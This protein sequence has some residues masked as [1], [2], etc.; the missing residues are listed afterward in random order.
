VHALAGYASPTVDIGAKN[1]KRF[2]GRE[3]GI[4]GK[5]ARPLE[6][7][8]IER[9]YAWVRKLPQAEQLQNR[10]LLLCVAVMKEGVM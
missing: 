6:D 4:K 7:H 9:M 8:V 2:M 5:Q 3:L 1:L 10:F